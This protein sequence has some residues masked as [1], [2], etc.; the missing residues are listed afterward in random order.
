MYVP[1]AVMWHKIGAYWGVVSRRKI[2]Q[3]LRSHAIFFWRYSPKLAWISTIPVSFLLD[4][5]RVVFGILT[6]RIGGKNKG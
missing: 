2:K 3:K 6:G 1:A 4:T 5:I